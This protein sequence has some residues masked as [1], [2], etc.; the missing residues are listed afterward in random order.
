MTLET[1]QL[2]QIA[3]HPSYW[4]PGRAGPTGEPHVGVLRD[5]DGTRV[6]VAFRTRAAATAAQV[7]GDV[8]GLLVASGSHVFRLRGFDRVDIDPGSEDAE[9]FSGDE[10]GALGVW[11]EIVAVE[12]AVES[13]ETVDDPFFALRTFSRYLVVGQDAED[14]PDLMLAPDTAG[15]KLLAVFTSEDAVDAF[16]RETG[17]TGVATTLPGDE[18]FFA[19][20]ELPIDGF[21]VNCCGPAATRAFA[22]GAVDRILTAGRS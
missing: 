17:A 14:A 8:G 15:R 7:S 18:L 13:P 3:G 11:A 9:S 21:V 20:R 1:A 5:A 6:L 12:R 16:V 2:R 19:M 10:L 4:I 22:K